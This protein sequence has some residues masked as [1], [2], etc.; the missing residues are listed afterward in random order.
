MPADRLIFVNI[1]TPSYRNE[2]GESVPGSVTPVRMWATRM[3]QPLNII[4]ETGGVRGELQRTWRIRWR[5]DV[6]GSIATNLKV[7]DGSLDIRGNN[8]IWGVSNLVEITGQGQGRQSLRRRFL[9]IEG[10]YSGFMKFP[11]TPTRQLETRAET[12]YTDTLVA[13][14]LGRAQGR[15]LAIPSATAALEMAAGTVGRGFLSCEVLGRPGLVDALTPDLL[16]MV[17]RSLIRRGEFIALID[18]TARRAVPTASR[19]V[20]RFRRAF[21]G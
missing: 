15:T 9:D 21:P 20:G 10:L 11:W 18:T 19:D 3:D 17:G 2:F 4:V 13:A 16:E 12:S 1:S 7:D 8:I 14:L 6:A 5:A